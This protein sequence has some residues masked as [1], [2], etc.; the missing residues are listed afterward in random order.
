VKKRIYIV[1]VKSACNADCSF[2][3]TKSQQK[4][5]SHLPHYLQDFQQFCST[6]DK[7]QRQ[8]SI[9]EFEITG[10]GEPFL[11]PRLESIVAYLKL[12]FPKCYIKI[13]TNGFLLP[14]KPIK[15][16]DEINLSRIHYDS[17][18]N[19]EIYRSSKQNE[20]VQALKYFKDN[21]K[22][23]RLNIIMMKGYIDSQE[24]LEQTISVTDKYVDQYFVRE[25]F[26]K[27]DYEKDKYT[28]FEAA[29]PKVKMDITKD[30]C[31]DLPIIGSDGIL[32]SD[33]TY[34]KRMDLT[35]HDFGHIL[36]RAII[37]TKGTR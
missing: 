9:E 33:W 15:Q 25:L 26:E 32:Y 28:S 27:C 36:E 16:I 35:K 37:E 12:F 34:R 10:G 29:H 21:H 6:L 18:K 11:H 22:K 4:Y 24:K 3:I 1:P 7:I 23:V 5:L 13:Y 17:E 8:T 31:G 20:I 14:V 19:N 30:Y 2:C